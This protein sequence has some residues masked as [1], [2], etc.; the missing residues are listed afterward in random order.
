VKLYREYALI[1]DQTSSGYDALFNDLTINI[2]NFFR[3]KIADNALI[4]AIFPAL[5]KKALNR[6]PHQLILRIWSAGSATGQEPFSLTTL[7]NALLDKKR[8]YLPGKIRGYRSSDKCHGG[9]DPSGIVI[10]F[11]GLRTTKKEGPNGNRF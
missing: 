6:N 5:I 7:L 10:L 9:G 1:L 8:L 11:I 4:N 2:T 3:D